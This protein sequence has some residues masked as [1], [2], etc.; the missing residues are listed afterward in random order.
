MSMATTAE[1]YRRDPAFRELHKQRTR[2]TYWRKRKMI[3][4]PPPSVFQTEYY[5]SLTITN[6]EDARCGQTI[7][8]PAYRIGHYAALFGKGPQTI[9]LMIKSGRIPAPLFELDEGKRFGRAYTYDQMRVT[10]EYLPLLNF[11]DSRDIPPPE[12]SPNDYG[13]GRHDP[14]FKR[15]HRAWAQEME[16]HRFDHN[17]FSRMLKE[18]WALMPD[19]VLV[20]AR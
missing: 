18:A 7:R 15:E 10:W 19:G 2:I 20:S 3:R 8:V 14:E 13:K 17:V 12:P 6:P 4:R 5:A 1:R 16:T 9:R 11:P